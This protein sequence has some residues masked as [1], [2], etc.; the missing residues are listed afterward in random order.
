LRDNIAMPKSNRLTDKETKLLQGKLEGK[1][2]TQA[3]LDAGYAETTPAG[4]RANTHKILTREHMQEALGQ[5]FGLD[6]AQQIVHNLF[7]I[8]T[9]SKDEKLQLEASKAWLDRA[10]KVMEVTAPAQQASSEG[11]ITVVVDSSYK[12]PSFRLDNNLPKGI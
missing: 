7:K 12:K 2:H 8:A 4:M 1:T 3:Y 11:N 6:E 9:T 5:L 10:I